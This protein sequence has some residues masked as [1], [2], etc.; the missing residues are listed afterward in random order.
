MSELSEL[1]D[2]DPM[3]LSEQ[4]IEAI[5]ARIREAQAQYELGAKP[6]VVAPRPKKSKTLDLLKDLG[7]GGADDPLKDLG[8]K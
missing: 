2:R 6:A 8:L 1:F 3:L 5:V 7:L 4:D